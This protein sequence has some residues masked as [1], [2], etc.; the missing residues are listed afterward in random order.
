M[1]DRTLFTGMLLGEQRIAAL[2]EASLF[3]LPSYQENFGNVVIESLAAGTPVVISDQVNI[4]GEI[5]AARVGGVVPTQIEPLAAE[6]IR[7]MTDAG[8]YQWAR[9]RA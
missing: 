9:E 3:V 7:W 6:I 8:L 1:T 5:K 4:Q 2:A